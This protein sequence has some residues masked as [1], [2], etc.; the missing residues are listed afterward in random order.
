MKKNSLLVA[1]SLRF[2]HSVL[3]VDSQQ[4]A[5]P[6]QAESVYEH[7]TT[8]SFKRLAVRVPGFLMM[9]NM[10]R[11]VPGALGKYDNMSS[12]WVA[13]I[14]DSNWNFLSKLLGEQAAIGLVK[15][16]NIVGRKSSFLNDR[17]V[18]QVQLL[19][20]AG[21]TVLVGA[22]AAVALTGTGLFTEGVYDYLVDRG[23]INPIDSGNENQ[24]KWEKKRSW[25]AQLLRG[26]SAR[27]RLVGGAF[28]STLGVANSVNSTIA[29][30]V[31]L[32]MY[33][34]QR[35]LKQQPQESLSK[36]LINLSTTYGLTAASIG[37]LYYAAKDIWGK[38]LPEVK[39]A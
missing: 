11:E 2:T 19:N 29:L 5:A 23:Y 36:T 30:S 13:V 39:T 9:I 14:R 28:G 7:D 26:S 21:R 15:A 38:D 24:T 18:Q 27:L 34:T 20:L 6:P 22:F 12:E 35:S 31:A 3:A 25:I 33:L 4:P 17:L 10:L 32:A 1:L 37:S 8:E 16:E